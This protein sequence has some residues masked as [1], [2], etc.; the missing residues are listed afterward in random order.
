MTRYR[1]EKDSMGPVKVPRHA[2]YGAQTQRA[3][4][5]FPVSGLRLPPEFIRALARIKQA[6][7]RVNADLGLLARDAAEAI[8]QAAGEVIEN[9]LDDQFPVDVFQTGSVTSTNMNINE[10]LSSRANEILT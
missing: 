6:A 4:D 7:A 8:A 5:N 1:E 3:V 9:R 2:Y 10:V